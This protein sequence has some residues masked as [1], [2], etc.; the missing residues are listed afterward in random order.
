VTHEA[1]HDVTHKERQLREFISVARVAL[2]ATNGEADEAKA[3]A[4][5]TQ[6]ELASELG[7]ISSRS[8]QSAS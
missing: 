4:V 2:D 7:F 5:A 3:V 1:L 8:V 6:V